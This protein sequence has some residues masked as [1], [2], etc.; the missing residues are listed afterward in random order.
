MSFLQGFQN[1][2]AKVCSKPDRMQNSMSTLNYISEQCVVQLVQFSSY[3]FYLTTSAHFGGSIYFA[4]KIFTYSRL[5]LICSYPIRVALLTPGAQQCRYACGMP[6]FALPPGGP[7]F[8]HRLKFA[9]IAKKKLLTSR[10]V[11]VQ[12]GLFLE[13]QFQYLTVF[14][15]FIC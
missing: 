2:F 11:K 5:P 15:N 1:I 10:V 13:S 7:P 9:D 14:S 8:G 4:L 12:N 3:H 6:S